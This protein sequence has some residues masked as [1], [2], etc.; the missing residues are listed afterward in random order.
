[1]TICRGCPTFSFQC[2]VKPKNSGV[3][4]GF[5]M[6]FSNK[7]VVSSSFSHISLINS[8]YFACYL[9]RYGVRIEAYT[10]NVNAIKPPKLAQLYGIL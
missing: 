9:E 8:Y 10:L 2:R 5:A 3:G 4:V 6:I 7:M 1:M